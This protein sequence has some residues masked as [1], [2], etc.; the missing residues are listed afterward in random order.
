M[1][2]LGSLTGGLS[3]AIGGLFSGS[4]PMNDISDTL[5][6]GNFFHE[7]AGQRE[8]NRQW[9]LEY[10]LAKK[11]YEEQVRMNDLNYN[12]QV[13]AYNYQKSLNEMQM[14]RE[15]NAVQR[16]VADLKAAGLS[17][18]L[19]AGS[20]AGATPVHAA[21]APQH[22]I[23]Q[24]ASPSAI[25]A[26][27]AMFREAQMKEKLGLAL[28]AMGNFAD[29]SR[30][31]AETALLNA[32]KGQ[33]DI[34]NKY[35]DDYLQGRNIGQNLDNDA[36]SLANEFARNANPE[37]LEKLK[38]ECDK[39]RSAKEVDEVQKELLK[40]QKTTEIYNQILK[41]IQ[42][43][44]LNA[45]ISKEYQ[46]MMATAYTLRWAQ[47]H[48]TPLSGYNQYQFMLDMADRIIDALA[49]GAPNAH[50]YFDPTTGSG[51]LNAPDA[52]KG[53]LNL[54]ELKN[55][56]NNPESIPLYRFLQ[57]LGW[58]DYSE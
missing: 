50:F 16:R 2:L 28:S 32:Q 56:Q 23:S 11:N 10:D 31:K 45:R 5:D 38:A 19:A 18:T 20:A 26:E 39:L 49:K 1:S 37:Q 8:A 35:L 34:I 40:E 4:N 36:K 3:D 22:G 47:E 53:G 17:P 33:Q 48:G 7:G 46:E 9:A 54:K 30:T 13:E 12:H 55:A 42:G 57:G 14:Q 21:N 51:G 43:S 58:F 25:K 52:S 6:P 29:V 27:A 44:E 41:G 24:H 15:D